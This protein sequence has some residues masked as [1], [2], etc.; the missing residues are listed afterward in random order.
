MIQRSNYY[1]LILILLITGMSCE[2]KNLKIDTTFC[3]NKPEPLGVNTENIRFS[4]NMTSPERCIEQTAYQILFSEKIENLKKEKSIL[5]NSGKINSNQSILVT[6]T[7]PKLASGTTYFWKVKV[8]DNKGNESEWSKPACLTTGLFSSG[9]WGEA[10]WIAYDKLDSVNRIV[11]GIHVPMFYPEWKNRVTGEHVLPILRKE[12]EAKKKLKEALVFVTGLGQYEL[13]LNGTKV[14]NHFLSPG[15]TDYDDSNLY[16]IYNITSQVKSGKN[17]FGMMLGNGFY[18]IPNTRY[19]KLITAYGNPKMILKLQLKYEDGSSET[20]V[21]DKS[22]KVWQS[23]VTYSSIYAGETYNATMEQTEWDCTGFDDSGWKNSLVVNASNKKLLP[24]MDYPV[25]VCETI[26]VKTV[27]PIPTVKNSYL[28]DFGQNA[29]GIVELEVLGKKGDTV[30]I[31]P[32]ELIKESLEADQKATGSPYYYTYILKGN[33]VE[34][35]APR[36]SYYGFRYAQVIGAVPD[37]LKGNSGLPRIKSLKFLHTRNSS[38]ETGSFATS[39]DLFDR[40]DQLIKWAIKSNLQSVMTDCPHREK[41]GWLEQTYLMGGSIHYNYDVYH[42]FNKLVDDMIEAQTPGGMVPAIVPEYCIMPGEF[43]D[44]PEWG[45]AAIFIPWMIYKYYGD[46][47]PMEKAW[48]MM[49]GYMEHMKSRSDNHILSFGLGDWYDLG[50]KDPGFAQLT[51]VAAT[52]TA[53]YFYDALLMN[54][55][56]SLIGKENEAKKYAAWAEEIRTAYNSKFLNPKTNIY[57]T[58]SQTAIAMPLVLGLVPENL[59]DKVFQTLIESINKS[60]KA[61][62]AGDVGFHFLV[63][64]LQDGGAGDLLFEM[65]ARDDVPGYGYQLKKGATA[66]TES[67]PALERVSNNHLMLGHLMEWFYNGLGGIDQT[68]ESVAYKEVL[69]APQIVKGIDSVSTDFKTPYGLIVS[70]WKKINGE[71]MVEVEIPVN[72]KA[73]LVLPVKG[74]SEILENGI[75]V[76]KSSDLKLVS[77][78]ESKTILKFGSGSYNFRFK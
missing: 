45:S 35:W 14:G 33:G 63:K 64:A 56:A 8:W 76:A 53:I 47:R 54:R 7:G 6:Y 38:P 66:L 69:I 26:F 20:I 1:L 16:N 23:P 24:E 13:R 17:A 44:S 2:K 19:R 41:L 42:L 29:S 11:P 67:W 15:W 22:W 70:K 12:F 25:A 40:V 59:K 52:A 61:L 46:I 36:F 28:Y 60:G 21:S 57:S 50:P 71:T 73:T 9:D 74:G 4:W 27:K 77:Q 37:T 31:Y 58:G 3:E 10:Q 43:R 32:A 72:T 65:N 5:W 55:M 75:S 34:K 68:D 78:T 51:P 49:A 18:I 62:T 48:Q 30:K 39:F